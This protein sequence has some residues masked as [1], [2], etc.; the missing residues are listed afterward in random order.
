M[1]AE[2]DFSGLNGERNSGGEGVGW[3]WWGGVQTMT[4][5]NPGSTSCAQR[6]QEQTE[7]NNIIKQ[8]PEPGTHQMRHALCLGPFSKGFLCVVFCDEA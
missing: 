2:E 3:W 8:V 6:F 5:E 7:D 4:S 1:W